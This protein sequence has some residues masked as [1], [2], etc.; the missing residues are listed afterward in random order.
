ML[1]PYLRKLLF[2][3]VAGVLGVSIFPSLASA[4]PTATY[5]SFGA[6]WTNIFDSTGAGTPTIQAANY[7]FTIDGQNVVGYCTDL[8]KALNTAATY[9]LTAPTASWAAQAAYIAANHLTIGTPASD[10][11]D[12]AAATQIAI[13]TLT[14]AAP[15]SPG[16]TPDATIL[17]RATELSTAVF[18]PPGIPVLVNPDLSITA[19]T[20]AT[21]TTATATIS[22]AGLSGQA[23]T[24]TL[25]SSVVAAVTDAAGVASAHLDGFGAVNATTTFVIAP[26]AMLIAA[27]TDQPVIIAQSFNVVRSAG[28]VSAAETPPAITVTPTSAAELPYTGSSTA[29]WMPIMG[30]LSVIVALFLIKSSLRDRRITS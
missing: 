15:L 21:G 19:V 16:T 6:G 12:E 1:K 5:S 23:I 22:G 17:A 24:F 14:N 9:T 3:T 27:P 7:N 30:I 8:T 26:G 10:S 4:S 28:V 2:F 11:N 13:W 20:D 25:G 18:V 29:T